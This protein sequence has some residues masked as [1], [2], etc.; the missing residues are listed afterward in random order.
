MLRRLTTLGAAIGT[1]ISAL[2]VASPAS[3]QPAGQAAFGDQGE[4]IFGADRLFSLF[5]YTNNQLSAPG[6]SISVSGTS[7]AFFGG[8]NSVSLATGNGAVS[9]GNGTFYNIP[10]LGFDYTIIKGLT[11]GG[12]AIA[13][14]TLG[15]NQ[16]FNN[17]SQ[18]T[19]GGNAFGIAPRVG[20][21]FSI[22]DVLAIWPRGGLSYYNANYSA[23][24]TPF[25]RCNDTANANLFGLD[26]DP[27]L[28]ISPVQHFAF[29]VGP[30]LDWGFT[31]GASTST[32]Q[33]PDCSRTQNF[34]Y[35]YTAVNF[36]IN[37]GLLGWF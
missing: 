12:E 26:V 14:F 10:R 34:S 35:T 37:A 29:Q 13:W 24:S 6:T 2:L 22:N 28:A 31:G 19:P 11:L 4:F 20:Y 27:V 17:A 25:P 36:A 5:A 30:T 1:A 23:Q 3:A 16:T 21:I 8:L 33:V 9:A 15:G 18:G 7:M 32:P